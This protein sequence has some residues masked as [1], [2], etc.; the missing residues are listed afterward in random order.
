MS[1]LLTCTVNRKTWV[2]GKNVMQKGM[3]ALLNEAGNMCCLGHLGIACGVPK[4][5]L[6]YKVHPDNLPPTEASKYPY[7]SGW[8]K[9]MAVND[10]YDTS[11]AEKEKKLREL[12][13]ENG[14]RFRFTGKDT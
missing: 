12:A 1:K 2:R 10:D 9:F 3:S 14:F 8:A 11:D 6:L 7:V 5:K 4:D 13:K